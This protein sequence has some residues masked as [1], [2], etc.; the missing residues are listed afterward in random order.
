M[1]KE[2]ITNNDK[3]RRKAIDSGRKAGTKTAPVNNAAFRCRSWT[4]QALSPLPSSIRATTVYLDFEL[5]GAFLSLRIVRR[6]RQQQ[7]LSSNSLVLSRSS[8]AGSLLLP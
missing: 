8:Q 2:M 5:P 6:R 4:I 1:K 7:R 3:G